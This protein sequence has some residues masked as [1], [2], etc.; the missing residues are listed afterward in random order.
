M[1]AAN[2]SHESFVQKKKYLEN[3]KYNYNKV[4]FQ[5]GEH[6]K[7]YYYAVSK[8]EQQKPVLSQVL[9]HLLSQRKLYKNKVKSEK[10]PFKKLLFDGMQLALKITANSVYGQ[11]GAAISPIYYKQLASSTT[12]MGRL[13]LMTSKTFIENYFDKMLK[14]IDNKKEFR[15]LFMDL[16]Q[17]K[18]YNS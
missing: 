18:I 4:E 14:Y 1:I 13:M 9:D 16:Y 7:R 10:D 6:T 17:T 2:I 12:A 15:K 8:Q 11:L 5:E 3:K